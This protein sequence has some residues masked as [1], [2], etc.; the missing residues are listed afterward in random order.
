[1]SNF[2]SGFRRQGAIFAG[3]SL[4]ALLAA[5][6]AAQAQERAVPFHIPA[7][8][9]SSAIVAF[10]Q[11]SGL[12]VG[13]NADLIAGKTS[14]A[15]EGAYTPAAGLQVLLQ[16]TG[17]TGQRAGSSWVLVKTV[18]EGDEPAT[19]VIVTG[20]HIRGGNPTSPVHTI[21]QK[22]IEQSGYTQIGDVV[23][24]LPESFGGGQNPGV[25]GADFAD[26]GNSNSSGAST[27]DLRGLGTDATL[28]LINGHR[29]T[30]DVTSQGAD[31]SPIPVSAV[32]RIE[33]VTD[34]ASSLYGADAVAG[35]VN[36]ILRKDFDGVETSA[37]VGAATEGGATERTF[38]VLGGKSW[39]R[40]HILA[41]AEYS[42]TD[43]LTT[44]DRDFTSGATSLS[45]IIQP[46]KR[47]SLFVS[48][49]YDFTDRVSFSG[50]FLISDREMHG[51]LQQFTTSPVLTQKIYTP[52]YSASATLDVALSS[53]WKARVVAVASGSHNDT[54]SAYPDYGL[55][56]NQSYANSGHYVEVNA[57]GKAFHLPSGDVKVAVGAGYRTEYW[58]N[59]DNTSPVRNV[60]YAFAEI[61][62]PLVAP[63]A[64]RAGL[65]ALDLSLSGRSEHYSDFG[66]STSPKVGLR[67]VPFD[68]LTLRA[69]WGKSFKAPSFQ[70]MYSK[71]VVYLWNASD[72]GG[73]VTGTALMTYGANPN[74]KPERS[75][76]K[77]FGADFTPLSTL[78]LSATWFDI[79]YTD[80]V[81]APVSRYYLGL[82][83]P[84]YAPF[85]E[86]APSAA[87]QAQVIAAGSTFYNFSAG[88]YDPTKVVALI[89]DANANANAQTVRGVDLSYRQSFDGLGGEMSTFANAT[90][91]KLQQQTSIAAPVQTL[92]GTVL[93][94]PR[95]K[96]RGGVNWERSGLSATAIINYLGTETDDLATPVRTVAPW[97]TVDT[98]ISY[99]FQ[100]A[101]G[102]AKGL[103][104][105]ASI[106]NLFDKMPPHAFGIGLSYPGIVFDSTNTSVVGRFASVSL[107]KAW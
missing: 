80:R 40:G 23:R 28:V 34:G 64:E 37:N 95:F 53:S 85:I 91:L 82:S 70:Q 72:V 13:G 78:K 69:T 61:L 9:L 44:A 39:N 56:S 47:R 5:A 32:Q 45:D 2:S 42:K 67:Y 50:D 29:L 59:Y 30:G 17:L 49:G 16:G 97:T 68:V 75:T 104:L 11:Q 87:R 103:T 88:A 43:G 65:H 38:S 15:I 105:A 58:R 3:V 99:R 52:S 1:M 57:D 12:T 4:L 83:D 19:E 26:I 74:L 100:A 93:N 35:V 79:D 107:K 63:S 76:S 101:H 71:S 36:F 102:L 25:I 73:T 96:A 98:T 24:S 10:S 106:S 22:D 21:D 84:I 92:S 77:T 81:V 8:P 90:W 89:N 33:V 20:T 66:S 60:S 54:W 27:A 18:A 62:A 46:A 94:V 55:T 14:T 41:D 51:V 48:G 7:Q 86:T 31:I 6:P